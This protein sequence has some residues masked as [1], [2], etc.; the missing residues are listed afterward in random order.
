MITLLLLTIGLTDYACHSDCSEAG[1]NYSYCTKLCSYGGDDT[2]TDYTYGYKR[3]KQI[4]Y[5]CL[6]DCQS[7]GYMYGYCKG[8]CSY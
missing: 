8:K 7:Q 1:Y 4:D 6:D 5:T 2:D 3:P